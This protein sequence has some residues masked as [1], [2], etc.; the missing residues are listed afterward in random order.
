MHQKLL[1]SIQ[2]PYY[3]VIQNKNRD[4]FET[5]YYSHLRMLVMKPFL[6]KCKKSI[7]TL[8]ELTTLFILS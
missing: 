3:L 1:K 8:L 6:A 2:L 7:S 5:G 4:F